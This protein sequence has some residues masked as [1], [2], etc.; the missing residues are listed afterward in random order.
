MYFFIIQDD[1]LILLDHCPNL[2]TLH[3]LTMITLA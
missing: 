1:F 3:K 2:P